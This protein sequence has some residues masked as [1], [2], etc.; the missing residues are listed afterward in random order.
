MVQVIAADESANVASDASRPRTAGMSRCDDEIVVSRRRTTPMSTPNVASTA[1]TRPCSPRGVPIPDQ[2]THDEPEIEATRMNQEALQDVGVAAQMGAPHPARVVEM[3]KRAFDPFA[4]L[5]HQAAAASSPHPATIAI[6][7][8][9]GLGILRPITSP[10]VRL[11]H[12]GPDTHGVQVASI[13]T[14]GTGAGRC[15]AT[16]P[17]P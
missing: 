17:V 16:H 7:R 6:H 15:A 8:R 12:V 4:A 3:R 5:A 2:M 14:L 11:G 9:P 1:A 10:P 13:G